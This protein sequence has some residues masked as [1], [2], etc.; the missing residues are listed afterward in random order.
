MVHG[1]KMESRCGQ[2]SE[3]ISMLKFLE[4]MHS[5]HIP[6]LRLIERVFFDS[7][8]NC[9]NVTL[10]SDRVQKRWAKDIAKWIARRCAEHAP[11]THVTVEGPDVMVEDQA[12]E[13]QPDS[14]PTLPP[15]QAGQVRHEAKLAEA[16]KLAEEIRDEEIEADNAEWQRQFSERQKASRDYI[17]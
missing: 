14:D 17:P 1:V 11:Y 12:G 7:H 5:G 6:V 16:L 3:M 8:H 2:V 10:R 9:L 13:Y 4:F 15:F